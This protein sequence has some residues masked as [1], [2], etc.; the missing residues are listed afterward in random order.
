MIFDKVNKDVVRELNKL[1]FTLDHLY[2][3]EC[4]ENGVEV[5]D[6]SE[7]I[8]QGLERKG[9]ITYSTEKESLTSAG[10]ILYN[11]LTD[12]SFSSAA[13]NVKGEITKKRAKKEQ[14]KEW[15]SLYP[16]TATW[17]DS[18]GKNWIDTRVLRKDSVE[19]E[20]NYMKV[21]N[22]GEFSHEEMCN[23]L[24]FQIEMVHKDSILHHE[25]KM[26]YF[27]GTTPYLNQET[28]RK[29]LEVMKMLKW[30][31]TPTTNTEVKEQSKNSMLL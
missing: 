2:V 22:S 16:A 29:Q 19:N 25:N 31:P 18:T 7:A 13:Q 3:L 10:K 15:L 5:S 8:T 23:A 27:Q 4:I 30:K 1:H 26:I 6:L 28:Y 24:L 11:L 14:Y 20:A 17:Q 12:P 21:I 9:Y